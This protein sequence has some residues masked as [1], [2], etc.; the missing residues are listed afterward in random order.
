MSL[1]FLFSLLGGLLVLA[2]LANRFFGLTRVPDVI[3][4]MATGVLLGPVLGLLRGAE[5]EPITSFFGTLALILILFEGGLDLEL[6]TTIRHFPGGVLLAFLAYA[7]SLAMVALVM[8]WS[9]GLPLAASITVAAVLAC[10]SSSVTLPVL[11]QIEASLA[12]RVTMFVDASMSDCFAVLTV[13]ILLDVGAH[14]GPIAERFA[15]KLALLVLISLL[16]AASAAILW[17]YLLPMISDRQFWNALTLSAVLL[18]YAGA[19]KA[20]ASGLIAVFGFGIILANIQRIDPEFLGESLGIKP[21][22]EARNTQMRTFYAELAFLVRTFFFVL[23]G[24]II[25]LKDLVKFLPQVLGVLG[26]LFLARALAVLVSRRFWTGFTA[27]EHELPLWIMPRGLITVVLALE[28]VHA[29][30]RYFEFLPAIAFAIIL[31]TNVMLV[32]GSIQASR[33]PAAQ[34]EPKAADGEKPTQATVT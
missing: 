19:E 24:L 34:S 10:T 32:V 25:E 17:S 11:Q 1:T 7:F 22:G 12:A 2:F 29:R 3:V 26:A 9:M 28:V 31:A 8:H 16:M 21:V 15:G 5:F 33:L 27:K 23:L 30:G 14:P 18:L 6:R 13:G 20:G 4:L